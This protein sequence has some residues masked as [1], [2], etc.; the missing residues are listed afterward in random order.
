MQKQQKNIDF[1]VFLRYNC[2]DPA[3][4]MLDFR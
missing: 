3:K 2:F 1:P 4:R